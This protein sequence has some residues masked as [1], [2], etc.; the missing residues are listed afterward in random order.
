MQVWFGLGS[1]AI[2]IDPHGPGL[3]LCIA[4]P[5][6]LEQDGC[7]ILPDSEDHHAWEFKLRPFDRGVPGEEGLRIWDYLASFL[8]TSPATNTPSVVE[9][10]VVLTRN[11]ESAW[12]LCFHQELGADLLVVLPPAVLLELED[13]F[14]AIPPPRP[15]VPRVI[16]GGDS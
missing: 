6:T 13:A 15:F 9:M 8:W 1:H 3:L 2:Q 7:A 5:G 12:S 10:K 14:R 16:K 11:S 4:K